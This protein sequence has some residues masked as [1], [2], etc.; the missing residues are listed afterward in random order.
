MSD[1]Y[2]I[3]ERMTLRHPRPDDLDLLDTLNHDPEVMRYLDRH[4]PAREQVAA[5]LA[6]TIEAQR[7]DRDHGR[8]IAEDRGT[9]AFL[10]W[11][12][13]EVGDDGPRAPGVGWRLRTAEWGRGLATEGAR[14]L[15][16]HAFTDLG[17]ERVGAET[18]FVNTRSRRVME[19]AGLR[20][21][22]VFHEH[23]DDPLPGTEHGEV[24]Y[25]ITRDAWLRAETP[26]R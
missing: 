6:A 7:A 18:M 3:T 10:G 9:G 26:A 4:P 15:V 19:K 14:A 1:A 25:E 8:F 17:A 11:F 2:L 24:W 22:R 21:V 13:L 5:E 16:A 12:G 23:F 20:L